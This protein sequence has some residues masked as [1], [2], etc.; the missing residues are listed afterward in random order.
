MFFA[1]TRLAATFVC[2]HGIWEAPARLKS[3]F[4]LHVA[5]P[6]LKEYL[7][8]VL[9]LFCFFA[10][11]LLVAAC[12]CVRT[13]QEGVVCVADRVRR[14]C[15][16]FYVD[17]LRFMEN[18]TLFRGLVSRHIRFIYCTAT[19]VPPG[20]AHAIDVGLFPRPLTHVPYICRLVLCLAF[21]GWGFVRFSPTSPLLALR[22]VRVTTEFPPA[23]V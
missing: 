15:L 17:I 9:Q 4:S 21:G 10:S 16:G 5:L 18:Q 6:C 8:I 1:H 11:S 14:A 22:G 12:V 20:W 2:S 19:L 7:I 13:Q 3:D 23:T